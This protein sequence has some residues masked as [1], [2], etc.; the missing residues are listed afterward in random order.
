MYTHATTIPAK[1]QLKWVAPPRS[2]SS[3][4][5]ASTQQLPAE[6]NVAS[7]GQDQQSTSATSEQQIDEPLGR[8][9]LSTSNSA[10]QSNHE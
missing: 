1:S 3:D 2:Q 8:V 7:P 10:C 5:D 4:R 6:T 9:L